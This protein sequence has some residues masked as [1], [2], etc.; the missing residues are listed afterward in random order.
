MTDT[1]P[2]TK[3]DLVEGNIDKIV[4]RERGTAMQVRTPNELYQTMLDVMDA[5]K[6]MSASG[7]LVPKWLQGNP[8]GCWGVIMQTLDWNRARPPEKHISPIFAARMSFEVNGVVGYM[9]QMF[10]T[11]LNSSGM[12]KQRPRFRYEG[13]GGTLKCFVTLH[14]KDEANVLEHE[15]PT[16]AEIK[17]KNSPLWT[18]DPK[19]QLSYY[20]I[21][22][23]GRKYCPEVFAGFYDEEEVAE[24]KD[25]TPKAA[26]PYKAEGEGYHPENVTKGLAGTPMGNE[27]ELAEVVADTAE[28]PQTG[29]QATEKPAGALEAVGGTEG[30]GTAPQPAKR[31]R[32]KAGA[33]ENE[34]QTTANPAPEPHPGETEPPAETAPPEAARDVEEEKAD[35]RSGGGGPAPQATESTQAAP[36]PEAEAPKEPS[37]PEG[38]ETWLDAWLAVI[39]NEDA[40]DERWRAEKDLRGRCM[41]TGD[42]FDRCMGKRNAR[43]KELRG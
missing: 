28:V 7:P 39:A 13:E 22:S 14:F 9:S 17:V 29:T 21:R 26:L 25:I 10:T 15:T 5:A 32:R 41:V 42:A 27:A 40:L 30:A 16:V 24:M 38:Y 35:I 2:L 19:Q 33:A 20:A 43:K 34:P 1:G 3:R 18:D 6:F 31:S 23:F 36:Q 4:T 8:G 37:S 11:L 12:F